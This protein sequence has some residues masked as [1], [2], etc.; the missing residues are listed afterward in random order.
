[1][2]KDKEERLVVK[3]GNPAV[4]YFCKDIRQKKVGSVYEVRRK[5]DDVLIDIVIF[6]IPEV[7]FS[8]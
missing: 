7:D 2:T 8:N 3:I 5:K 4:R 6:P 1:M